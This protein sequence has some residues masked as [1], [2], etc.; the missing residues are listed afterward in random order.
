MSTASGFGSSRERTKVA[1]EHGTK[2]T[3]LGQ[4]AQSH[5]EAGMGEIATTCS[6]Q[7]G[8]RALFSKVKCEAESERS[9]EVEAKCASDAKDGNL[10]D[11]APDAHSTS[12]QTSS[13]QF[14]RFVHTAN[15]H[16]S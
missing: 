14:K 11:K 4:Q 8:R 3:G 7:K 16:S 13:S 5:T 15:D 9:V 2:S 12:S 6:E 1:P 10:E